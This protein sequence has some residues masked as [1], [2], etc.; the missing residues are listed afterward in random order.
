MSWSVG[1]VNLRVPNRFVHFVSDFPLLRSCQVRI[2]NHITWKKV[3]Q[4]EHPATISNT[5]AVS[6]SA[7][8]VCFLPRVAI[9][10]LSA[11]RDSRWCTKKWREDRHWAATTCLHT[12]QLT[13]PSLTPTAN[14]CS[15]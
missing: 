7:A 12:S 9:L 13:P 10:I 5:K 2:L 1:K 3:A 14:V 11:A 4:F 15:R 8:V 6:L